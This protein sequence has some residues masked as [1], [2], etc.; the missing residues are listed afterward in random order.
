[1]K[2]TKK[3][4]RFNPNLRPARLAILAAIALI[5]F[6]SAAI[7][8]AAQEVK[9]RPALTLASLKGTW[10]A[11]IVLSGGCGSGSKLVTFTLNASG[12]GPA[13]WR[14]NSAECGEDSGSGTITITSLNTKGSGTAELAINFVGNFVIQVS[15]NSQV[16]NMVEI[17]DSGNFEV[18]TAIKQ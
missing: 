5:T 13:S 18:A 7:P 8:A 17:T 14:S 4:T 11:G 1:M 15:S 9:A 6:V 16:M 2:A 10:Q 3:V 12:T